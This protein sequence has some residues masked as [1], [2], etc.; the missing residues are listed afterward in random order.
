[1]L[2]LTELRRAAGALDSRLAGSRLER[3]AQVDD[4]ELIL[5]LRRPGGCAAESGKCHVL[6]SCSP[7][8]A[9][10]SVIKDPPQASQTPP[11][12]TQHLRAYL[13]RAG[14]GAIQGL[15]EDRRAPVHVH[16]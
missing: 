11:P 8:F 5:S 4:V 3:V 6:L 2:S 7:E 13:G 9:R 12:F 14:F 1:M 16:S 10:L 15:G